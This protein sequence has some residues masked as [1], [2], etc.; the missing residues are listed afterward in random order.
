M[1]LL[2]ASCG[3][4]TDAIHQTFVDMLNKPM[5]QIRALFIPTAANSPDA[6]DDWSQRCRNTVGKVMPGKFV[7]RLFAMLLTPIARC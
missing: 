1:N 6:I 2:L 7:P 4:E 3:L 5:N